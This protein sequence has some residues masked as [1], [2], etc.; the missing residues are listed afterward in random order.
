VEMTIDR[1]DIGVDGVDTAFSE[2]VGINQRKFAVNC[3]LTIRRGRSVRNT[4][5]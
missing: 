2:R 4:R 1:T 5:R 3:V